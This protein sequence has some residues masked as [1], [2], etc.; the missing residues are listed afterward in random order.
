MTAQR[1]EHSEME[2]GGRMRRAFRVSGIVQGV[3]F[4]PF[5]YRLAQSHGLGG[6]VLN[7]SAGVGIE[8]EGAAAA[9]DA[10]AAATRSSAACRMIGR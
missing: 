4:R 8:A 2:K 5:V 6:W 1:A 10:F 9:L 7:D 3:G